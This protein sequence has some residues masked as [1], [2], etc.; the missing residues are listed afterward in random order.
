MCRTRILTIHNFVEV[1]WIFSICRFQND[2][3]SRQRNYTN[4]LNTAFCFFSCHLF[5][6]SNYLFFSSTNKRRNY[7]LDGDKNQLNFLISASFLGLNFDKIYQDCI[8]IIKI[9]QKTN[10]SVVNSFCSPLIDWHNGRI[11]KR[12]F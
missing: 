5:D 3:L 2:F 12:L 10:Q 1:L 4:D 6:S 8:P 7:T 11:V 9:D